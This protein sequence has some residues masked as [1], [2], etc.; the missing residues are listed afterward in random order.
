MSNTLINLIPINTGENEVEQDGA[1]PVPDAAHGGKVKIQHEE[2]HAAKETGHAHRDA[3]VAGVRVVVEDAEQTLAADVD[4]A[5]V[6]D[7]AEHHDGENLRGL[8]ETRFQFTMLII[9]IN[10]SPKA[11]NQSFKDYSPPVFS[12]DFKKN[13]FFVLK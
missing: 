5:L 13:M 3:V 7:A 9:Q 11:F 10:Q 1:F 12:A 4:V 2:K 8:G 6:D